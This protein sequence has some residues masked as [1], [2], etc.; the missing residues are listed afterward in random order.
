MLQEL[1]VLNLAVVERLSLPLSSG[2]VVLTG[3][4]GAGKSI[5]VGALSALL[6]GRLGADAIRSGSSSARVE[7]IFLLESPHTELS[8]LLTDAGIALEDDQLI[9]DRI[10][11][12]L[13]RYF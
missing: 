3:E 5:L 13:E 6:G 4:T 12:L 10:E 2:F 9:V 1:T 8:S 7:G 11:A